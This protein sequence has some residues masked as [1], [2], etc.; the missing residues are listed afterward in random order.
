MAGAGEQ[1]SSHDISLKHNNAIVA[2]TAAIRGFVVVSVDP[3]TPPVDEDDVL[4]LRDNAGRHHAGRRVGDAHTDLAATP[5]HVL[6][7]IYRAS[8]EGERLGAVI[9]DVALGD[10]DGHDWGALGL[11]E[12]PDT[13]V[14]RATTVAPP[15]D[16]ALA[17][18]SRGHGA[19]QSDWQASLAPGDA[20]RIGDLVGSVLAIDRR[21]G[22]IE[23][24]REGGLPITVEFDEITPQGDSR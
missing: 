1:V 11:P 12:G 23:V 16:L 10:A 6:V 18:S 20:V 3:A 13:R 22:A 24:G 5:D 15:D 7:G 8:P 21:K 4:V 14:V 2:R 17:S 19:W 9:D